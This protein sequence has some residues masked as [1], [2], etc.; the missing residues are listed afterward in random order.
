MTPSEQLLRAVASRAGSEVVASEP[1]SGG[2]V[3]D[4]HRI[5]LADGRR[6]CVKTHRSPPPQHFSTEAAGLDWLRMADVVPVPEVVAVS[7]HDPA[8]LLIEWIEEGGRPD[9]EGFGRA[10]ARLHRSGSPCFGRPDRRSTGSRSLPNEP[11]ATWT[12]FYATQRLEPLAR[13]AADA[14]V[15]D[16]TALADLDRVIHRLEELGGTP[17]PPSL[18]HG[19][20]W[21]GNR[22]VGRNGR[23]W[24][25]DPAAHGGHR[26][27]DLAMMR[28]FGGFGRSVFDAYGEVVPLAEGWQDRVQLHQLAPLLVHAVKFGGGYVGASRDVLLRYR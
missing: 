27:F 19:D 2:D 15:L 23:S 16:A 25:I 26:E 10:L 8:F 3:A 12:E 14:E 24:L 21:A 20:L 5:E 17:E 22:L 18:L 9:E 11:C 4:T 7:D 28:L 6:C 1:C 13:L